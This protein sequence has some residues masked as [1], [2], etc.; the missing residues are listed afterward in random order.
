[1]AGFGLWACWRKLLHDAWDARMAT[2]AAAV[3]AAPDVVIFPSFF[4]RK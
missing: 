2:T 1:M 3:I 4:L